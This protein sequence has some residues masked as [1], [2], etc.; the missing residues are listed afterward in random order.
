ME[1]GGNANSPAVTVDPYDSQKLLAVWGVDLSTLTPVPHTTAI[2]E[3]AYSNNGGA[4]WN[5]I[6]V[7][8]PI[9]DAATIGATPPTA[10]TQVTQ[11]SVAFDG[12]GNVYVL[13]SQNSGT[14][15]GALTLSKYNFSGNT[16][17]TVY[18]DRVVSRWLS[19][20]D[21]VFSPTLAV[22]AAPSP[23]PAGVPVDPHANNVYIAWASGDV[24]PAN[25]NVELQ[26]NPNRIE[27][28]VS[29]DGG[30]TFSG[31]TIAD[32]DGN[33]GGVVNGLEDDSHPQLAINQNASG[34]ITVGWDNFGTG[35]KATPKFDILMSNLVQG[36]N[37][38]GFTNSGG[39]IDPGLTGTPN[40]T[41][42]TTPFTQTVNVPDPAAITGLTVTLNLIHPTVGN[43]SIVLQAPN[44][45]PSI[46]LLENATDAA[47]AATGNGLAGGNLGVFGETTTNPG[48]NIGTVFDDN[49]T[50]GIFDP[51]TTGTNGLAAPAIGHFQ[52]ESGESLDDFVK[53]VAA[54]GDLNGQW[55]L[56]ITD[57]R[58]E[59]TPGNVRN[60]TLQFTT[61]MNANSQAN[62]IV[63]GFAKAGL[64]IGGSINNTYPTAAIH[65]QRRRAGAGNGHRQHNGARQPESRQDL[66]RVHRIP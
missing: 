64:V 22:D 27:L 3:G 46:T 55:T 36:G 31:E 11:P 60:F 16:P 54:S 20:S 9:L 57:F 14:A 42:V 15:D 39:P 41:A 28:A 62:T 40:D 34:Q 49:A 26:F 52:P 51:T 44:G 53:Q 5:L 6:D 38:Y 56:K 19:T 65:A 48:I 23:A 10:Y 18:N 21:A 1:T 63:S 47:G 4:N 58:T 37:S 45:G 43:L 66:R 61:G 13:A 59:T 30:I 29:T 12:Q 7:A 24:H 32:T 8:D 35:S 50:R 25:P 2:V 17:Q 33:F